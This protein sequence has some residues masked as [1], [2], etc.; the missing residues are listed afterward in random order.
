MLPPVVTIS[1][2]VI[3]TPSVTPAAAIVFPASVVKP[4]AIE[5][6][7][8]VSFKPGTVV[9]EVDPVTIVAIPGR[10]LI[11]CIAGILGFTNIGGGIISTIGRI[12]VINRGR[13]FIY[14]SGSGV[15][16][17]RCNIHPRTGD[18]KA[19]VRVYIYL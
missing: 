13:L 16:G 17:G 19:D 15:N 10:V 12:L 18:T 6:G 7:S 11:V 2:I 1:A 14:G 3:P 9:L 4:A 8:V 5:I